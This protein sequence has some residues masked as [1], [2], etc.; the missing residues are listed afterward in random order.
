M[1]PAAP[2]HE[3]VRPRALARRDDLAKRALVL[4]DWAAVAGAA[5]LMVLL[6]PGFPPF[7][8]APAA[9]VLV[10]LAR[11]FGLY[12]RDEHVLRK[13]TLDEVP[14]LLNVAA[15]CSTGLWLAEGLAPAGGLRP[16]Q[17][18]AFV[19]ALFAFLVG[20]RVLARGAVARTTA[21]ERCLVVGDA[22]SALRLAGH[23]R[24]DHV[25]AELVGRV[26]LDQRRA[27]DPG[28]ASDPVGPAVLG[29]MGALAGVLVEH[30]IAR[31]ILAP[32]N[33]DAE[34]IL[35]AIRTVK[36]LGI[37]VSILPR[38]FEAVESSVEFDD[39][40]AITLLSVRQFG[41]PGSA[42]AAKRGLDVLGAAVAA[43]V[44][45][46]LMIAIAVA[47]KATSPGPVVFRQPRIGRDGREFQI[48]KFRSMVDGA[49]ALKPGLVHL[50]E[51]DG[52]FKISAD[53]RITRVGAFLRASS[54]DELPQLWNVV[55]GEMSLVGPRPLVA[56]DDRRV[57]GWQRRRLGISPGMTGA[58]QLLGSS[59]IPLQE[60]VKIDYLYIAN[61]SLW[62]DVKILLR[63]IP[64]VLA[65][66]SM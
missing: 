21:P 47:I 57:E 14:R 22:A 48:L 23:L 59:R 30:R 28:P 40:G 31:V 53:P 9:V 36:E 63:T 45:A 19:V 41:L 56:E 6:D 24:H 49:D 61:W 2:L 55:R 15:L 4:A 13:G 18:P 11:A 3:G 26:P 60:M 42:R 54:L 16:G 20:A 46:P 37:K 51:A 10:V 50:N 12:G 65:R 33:S 39:L 62:A 64:Y 38:L 34:D 44:F 52:L 66:R 17:G 25:R 43:V 5:G 27:G 7:A 8:A 1:Q 32:R 35:D 29:E 58:W